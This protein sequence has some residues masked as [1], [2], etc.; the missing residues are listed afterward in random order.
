MKSKVRQKESLKDKLQKMN[1]D[2]KAV[3][4]IHKLKMEKK[5]KLI[6]P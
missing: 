1:K 6:V 2:K 5:I 3:W 4:N